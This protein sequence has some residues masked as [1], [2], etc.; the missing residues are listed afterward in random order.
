MIVATETRGSCTGWSRRTPARRC[1][2]ANRAA[3]CNY[4]KMITLPK[5]RVSLRD[6]KPEVRVP[7]AVA[8]RARV[9]IERMVSIG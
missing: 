6:L 1:V 2:P 9:R 4:M 3:V 8:N 5:L 7:P